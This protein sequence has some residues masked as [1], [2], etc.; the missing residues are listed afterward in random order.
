MKTTILGEMEKRQ[1]RGQDQLA[2][3]VFE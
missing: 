2:G 1:E 3:D